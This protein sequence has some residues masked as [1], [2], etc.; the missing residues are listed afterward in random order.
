M[1]RSPA[2]YRGA[3][4]PVY[5]DVLD[6]DDL[7]AALVGCDSAYYLVHSLA[8]PISSAKTP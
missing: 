4:T 2:A 5:G 7:A 3:G 1:T 8:T 6:D